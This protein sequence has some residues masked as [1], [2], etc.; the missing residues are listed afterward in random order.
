MAQGSV[1][2]PG[3]SGLELQEVIDAIEQLRDEIFS[4]EITTPLLCS[5]GT[6]L[7]TSDGEPIFARR[8]LMKRQDLD[9]LEAR[10]N[11][12]ADSIDTKISAHNAA[13]ESHPRHLV[14]R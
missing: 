8:V 13:V 14:V 2:A 9:M 5:D 10:L 12:V 7:C 3:V 11:A 6:P 4:G 1:N